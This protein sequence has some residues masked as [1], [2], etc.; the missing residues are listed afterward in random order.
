M[1]SLHIMGVRSLCFIWNQRMIATLDATF[2]SYFKLIEKKYPTEFTMI[3]SQFI[4]NILSLTHTFWLNLS[5]ATPS[6]QT[7]FWVT[8]VFQNE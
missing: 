3:L 4:Q 6:F 7:D 2:I 1:K 5:M 8:F